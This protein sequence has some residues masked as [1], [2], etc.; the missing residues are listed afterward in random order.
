MWLLFNLNLHCVKGDHPLLLFACHEKTEICLGISNT[1]CLALFLHP[2][3][4]LGNM[5]ELGA[6]HDQ[7]HGEKG[8]DTLCSQSET[9]SLVLDL[10]LRRDLVL[11]WIWPYLF[12][13]PENSL[14]CFPTISS[15]K[16]S[17][18]SVNC[19]CIPGL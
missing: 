12:R 3:I 17:R 9:A 4:T 2:H 1:H 11:E 18:H 6:V 5:T 19:M 10:G 15:K 7:G 13:S 14:N 16:R 8:D